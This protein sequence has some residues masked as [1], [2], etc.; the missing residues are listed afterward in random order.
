MSDEGR[1]GHREHREHPFLAEEGR[2][3]PIRRFRG[4]LTAP[5]TI[6]TAGSERESTGLTVSSMLVAEGSPSHVLGLL[7]DLTDLYERLTETGTFVVHVAQA[8]DG[9]LADRF[10]GLRPSPGGP[11][12][13]VPVEGSDWGPVLTDLT[14]RAYCRLTEVTDAGYQRLVKGRIE[15]LEVESLE[16]PLVYF[17]GRYKTLGT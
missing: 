1:T 9:V 2:R 17:R 8:R 15:K 13:D 11:F 14:T 6:W 3:E 12:T 4:R 16:D 5:V 7:N 10:A